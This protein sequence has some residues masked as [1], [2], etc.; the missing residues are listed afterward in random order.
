MKLSTKV[1]YNA[2]VQAVSKFIATILGLVAIALITRYLGQ[3]GFGQYTTIITFIS[4]FAVIADLGLTLITVQ[5]I[6]KPDAHL[7]RTL[8]NLLA[9]RLVSAII[10]LGIAPLAALFF[11]YSWEM[12]VGIFITSFAFLFTA[13]G[14]ILVGLFQK[15][16]RMDK[17][18]IAEIVGRA[19]L[20]IGFFIVI[21]YNYGL[22]GILAVTVFSNAASFLLQYLFAL[23][24]LK[25]KLQFDFVFWGEIIKKSWPLATTIILNLIYLRTDTLLLSIIPRE[26]E[27]GIL[28]EVGL[29]GAA[30]KVIDVLITLPFMFAGIILPI[31]T[32][33]WAEKNKAGFALVL[34]KS[35]DAM[36]IVAIP[37]VIGTQLVAD[38]IITVV[39]GADFVIAGK[40]LKLLII[41]CGAIFF[42]NIFAHA[43]IAIDRQ[44]N[45][46]GAY[47]F[48]AI[49][50]V[51][52]YLIFIPLYTY[53]GAA[54]VTIY[55]EVVISLASFYLV[56]K[57][58]NFL[59]KLEVTLKAILAS[60][61]MGGATYLMMNYY[62]LNLLIVLAVA[63]IIY[64]LALLSIGGLKKEDLLILINK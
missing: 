48:T 22:T 24:F 4:F 49:T 13:L 53:Y 56:W 11:P 57:Y 14:Q 5:M 6:S 32:A 18:S 50:S 37:L 2:I 58:T 51:I 62:Q 34:Q 1:A 8:G 35:F 52:G 54:W 41:A 40:I 20:V 9:L 47:I 64:C 33:R 63:V 29:Y 36:M 19:L 55:S 39:A 17:A 26:S 61:I 27:I 31:L 7:D 42:G 59:P 3:T 43:V 46:I 45:I 15:N 10:L 21:K 60:L 23:P 25:I 38:Q 30:Y 12:K 28:A 16:L 44:K